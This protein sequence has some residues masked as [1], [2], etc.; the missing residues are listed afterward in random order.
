MEAFE[1]LLKEHFG[2]NPSELEL[3]EG[4]ADRTYR[5]KAGTDTY[6]LKCQ[7]ITG[8]LP[9]RFRIERELT[10]R[11]MAEGSYDFPLSLQT[12]EGKP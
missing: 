9:E 12:K 1:N 2:L 3:L 4:Y 11:L 10:S 5:V 6:I 8:S 7:R